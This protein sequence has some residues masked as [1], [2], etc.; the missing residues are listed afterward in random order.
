M[1]TT[2][3]ALRNQLADAEAADE[4]IAA[5]I[6]RE[7]T[8]LDKLERSFDER[9]SDLQKAI[10]ATGSQIRS[11]IAVIRDAK[12]KVIAELRGTNMVQANPPQRT[13]PAVIDD[14]GAG[15]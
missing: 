4:R 13:M 6:E 5:D 9:L 15:A 7:V 10:A 11:E 3:A 12:L 1:R 8:F 14:I 2:T